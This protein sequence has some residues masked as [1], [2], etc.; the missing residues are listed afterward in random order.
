M[1]FFLMSFF[2]LFCL[3]SIMGLAVALVLIGGFVAFKI[4]KKAAAF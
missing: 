1:E 3:F 4:S 2:L